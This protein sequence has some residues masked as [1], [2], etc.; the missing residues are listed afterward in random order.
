M[1]SMAVSLMVLATLSLPFSMSAHDKKLHKGNATEGEITSVSGDRF[2]MKT[3][4]G[5]VAV[6]LSSK[7]TFEHG[8]E[9]VDKTHLKVGEHVSVFGT[10]VS[11]T[12]IS[13]SSVLLGAAGSDN[14]GNMKGMDKMKDMDHSKM[15]DP[16]SA[17]KP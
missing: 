10:K 9:V 2:Q 1:R 15:N 13:A 5:T 12:E 7:T 11:K 6:K 17:P 16:K 14:H 4:T 3:A 8:Q